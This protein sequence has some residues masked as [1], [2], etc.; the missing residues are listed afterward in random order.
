MVVIRILIVED[1]K[2]LAQS[3]AQILIE[4][5][6][7]VDVVYD[8]VSGF[9]S[10]MSMIYDVIVLDVMLPYMN[11][12]EVVKKLRKENNHTP[13][14]ILTAK[15]ETMD[16]VTGLDYGADYYLTKPFE[17]EEL[18]ACIRAISRRQGEVIMDE[19]SFGDIVLNLS[20]CNLSCNTRA[21][22]LGFKEFEV[23]RMLLLNANIIV[24]KESI[25]L[26][27]WG[28]ESDAEDNNVEAYVSFLRKK[29]FYLKS[30]VSILA[31][32][33]IGYHLVVEE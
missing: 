12:F 30:G 5:K 25:L 24:S 20:T 6:Y 3:L 29:L 31:V 8:G 27:I 18:L 14:L 28:T 10:A 1:E 4:N 2:R 32:R 16:K 33:K 15:R 19:L 26:K 9:D 22:R 11:G 23:M 13:V 21:V 17:T 7:I